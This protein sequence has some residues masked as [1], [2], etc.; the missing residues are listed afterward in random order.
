MNDER[1]IVIELKATGANNGNGSG[2]KDKDE[3]N[4]LVAL[5]KAM[6]SPTNFLAKATLGKNVLM[7]RTYQQAKAFIKAGTLYFIERYFNLTENYKAEQD[8]SN[9]MSVLNHLTSAGTSILGGAIMGAKASA[10]N[11]YVALIGAAVGAT[12]WA[13]N[14][15][16]NTI[17]LI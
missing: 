15:L 6:Q 7:Y 16:I 4:D 9:T 2:G 11:P 14:E 13:G 1:K 5:L 17:K 10:G 8:L 12:A 3:D